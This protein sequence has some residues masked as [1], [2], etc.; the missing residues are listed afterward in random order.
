MGGRRLGA[1]WAIGL[2]VTISAAVETSQ[3][4]PVPRPF[5]GVT[6]PGPTTAKPPDPVTPATARPVAQ[7]AASAAADGGASGY[8]YPGAEFV[9]SFNAGRGQRFYLYGTN[10]PFSD[11]VLHYKNA[12]KLGG[13]RELMRIPPMQQFDL[14]RFDEEAMAFPPSVV[15]KDYIWNNSPG[16]LHVVGT[17]EKRFKTII[18]IVPPA[19]IK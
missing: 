6:S 11:V 14:G 2:T 16:Y 7:T 4:P 10:A 1:A 19:P 9:G 5:P 18:Q 3:T 13:G 8:A 15:V 12:L 17:T